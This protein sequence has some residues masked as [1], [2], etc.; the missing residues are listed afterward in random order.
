MHLVGTEEVTDHPPSKTVSMPFRT[1][2]SQINNVNAVF[3]VFRKLV[4]YK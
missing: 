1:F 4:L 3:Y 2:G